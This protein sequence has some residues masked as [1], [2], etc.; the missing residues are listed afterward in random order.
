[1]NT[2]FLK[3]LNFLFRRYLSALKILNIIGDA[4]KLLSDEFSNNKFKHIIQVGG[5]DGVSGDPIRKY[6]INKGNFKAD[7]FEPL[8]YYFQKLKKLYEDRKDINVIQKFVSDKKNKELKIFYIPPEIASTMDGEGP[9]NGWAH[10]Q[11]SFSKEF[12]ENEI[13]KNS[14]RGQQY[15]NKILFYKSSIK[16]ELVSSIGISEI[17]ID[18]KEINLLIIDVQG[19]EF[20]VLNSINF[21]NQKFNLIYYE[22]ESPF[23][24]S[25]RKIRKLLKSKKYNL[26]GVS[27]QNFCFKKN[28]SF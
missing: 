13:E 3:I 25:S 21:E 23:S 17:F 19:H 15:I 16:S 4:D 11:G 7:I 5:N 20:N 18:N 9:F 8:N 22:D 26:I 1:M 6:L 10:G 14:F 2:I 24:T 12:I 28:I 27:G